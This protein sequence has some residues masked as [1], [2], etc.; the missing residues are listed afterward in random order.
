M[1]NSLYER[2]CI[3]WQKKLRGGKMGCATLVIDKKTFDMVGDYL[4]AKKF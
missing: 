3:I 4:P 2:S 1:M